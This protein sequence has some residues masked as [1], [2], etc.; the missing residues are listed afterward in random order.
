MVTLTKEALGEIEKGFE[1]VLVVHEPMEAEKEKMDLE[2]SFNLDGKWLK[3]V[4]K[5]QFGKLK[6]VG[7]FVVNE[8][9]LVEKELS[10]VSGKINISEI[11]ISIQKKD[12]VGFKRVIEID[13]AQLEVTIPQAEEAFGFSR[14]TTKVILAVTLQ[15]LKLDNLNLVMLLHCGWTDSAE[16]LAHLGFIIMGG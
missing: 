8:L 4:Q 13:E 16:F 2:T 12:K 7:G 9:E 10:A 11:S 1:E 15:K 6:T 5:G 14:W 3:F